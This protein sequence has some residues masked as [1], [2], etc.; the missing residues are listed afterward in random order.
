MGVWAGARPQSGQSLS[1]CYRTW[2]A[3][4]RPASRRTSSTVDVLA[5]RHPSNGTVKTVVI[6]PKR[7]PTV[8]IAHADDVPT[9]AITDEQWQAIEHAYARQLKA[10]VRQ[11]ITTV[12]TQYLKDCVFDRAAAPKAMVRELIERIRRGAGD[13]EKVMKPRALAADLPAELRMAVLCLPIPENIDSKPFSASTD[14]LSREQQEQQTVHS[15]A[16]LLIRRYFNDPRLRLAAGWRGDQFRSVLTS[17][18]VA[19]DCALNDLSAA[20]GYRGGEAW[21]YWV[22]RLTQIAQEHSLPFGVSTELDRNGRPLPFV[23]LVQELERYLPA[24]TPSRTRSPA[25]LA[26][27]ISRARNT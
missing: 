2:K 21:N 5:L 3:R 12:T 11:R 10:G 17:L 14:E 16:D 20:E 26:M 18:V 19:C 8:P 15:Y 9:F 27:A 6:M 13:L 22:Q 7:R 23:R 4:G 24:N 1:A 25:A